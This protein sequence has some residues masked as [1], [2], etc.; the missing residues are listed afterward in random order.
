MS[1]RACELAFAPHLKTG[2]L[3]IEDEAYANEEAELERHVISWV[4]I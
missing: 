1:G 4:L 3:L 2:C